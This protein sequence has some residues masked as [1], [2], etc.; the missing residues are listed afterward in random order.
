MPLKKKGGQPASEDIAEDSEMSVSSP[1]SEASTDTTASIALSAELLQQILASTQA[2]MLAGQR[3]LQQE[4]LA[5]QQQMASERAQERLRHQQTLVDSQAENQ[6]ALVD[7]QRLLL[8]DS[9]ATMARNY[10]E[11]MADN[12]AAM[13]ILIASL[14]AK[15]VVEPKKVRVDVPKWKE[16]EA[17]HEYFQ[18]YETAQ[19][20]NGV[21]RREWGVLLQVY[22][23]G[24]AQA[25]Y[26]QVNPDHYRDYDNLKGVMLRALRDTPEQADRNWWSLSRKAGET[27]NAF[28]IRMRTV[29]NRRFDGYESRE[30][31]FEKVLLS[32]FLYLLPAEQYNLVTMRDPQTTELAASILDD[33]ES[34]AEFANKH[35]VGGVKYGQSSNSYYKKDGGY[36]GSQG[37]NKGGGSY[38]SNVANPSGTHSVEP[39][40]QEPVVNG[41]V[42]VSSSAPTNAANTNVSSNNKPVRKNPIICYSCHEPGHIKPNCPNRIRRLSPCEEDSE[43]DDSAEP[44]WVDG[45]IGQ[46]QITGMRYDSGCDRTVVDKQLV[47]AEAYIGQKVTLKGWR[48]K[49]TSN[50]ELARINIKVGKVLHKKKKVAVAEDMEY[51]A[52]LGAD[53]SR[54]IRCEIMKRVM[55]EWETEGEVGQ[56]KEAEKSEAVRV[57][58]AQER[59]EDEAERAD[60]Q[61]SE[62]SDCTPIP[63]SEIFDF[64]DE[65]F[66]D[67]V[68]TPLAELGTWLVE[69]A[70]EPLVAPVM[71]TCIDKQSLQKEQ[72]EDATLT[73]LHVLAGEKEKGYRYEDGILLQGEE[74]CLGDVTSRIVVPLGRRQKLLEL[75]HSG[76]V[77]GHFGVKKTYAK[78]SGHFIWPKMWVQV[79]ELVRT[80]P[81]CQRASRNTNAK[82]PLQP[83]P[84]I[85]EP[86]KLVAFDI[87]GPIPRS[88]SGYKYI[89]TMM[90]LYTK[91]PEAIP[92]KRVDN[93]AVLEGMMEVFTRHGIPERILTDQGTVFMSRLTKAV[94]STLGID[95]IR[96][97]PYH[98]QSN[99]ALER[100]H[101][102]LKGMLKRSEA[103]LKYWDRHLKYLLFAYRDTPHCITGFSPFSLLFGREVKGPLTL[104][105]SSWLEGESEGV[106][107]SVWVTALKQQMALMSEVVTEKEKVAKAKM[108]QVF[109]KSAKEKSFNV[110]DLVLIRKPGLKGKLGDSWDGPYQILEKISPLNYKIQ[111]PGRRS[112]VLHVNLL[113]KWSTP[114]ARV[115][116]VAV[117]HEEEGESESPQ[118]LRLTRDG[119]VPTVEQQQLLDATLAKY[120]EVLKEMPGRTKEITLSIDTA[121]SPPLR[122]HPYRIPPKWREEVKEQID[123]LLGLG[124]IEVSA[125]P[126]SSAVVTVRKKT[127]GVRICIDYRAINSVTTP[128]PYQMPFIEDILDTL[129]SAKYMSKID[130]NKGF[131]QIPVQQVDKAKTAFCTPWGKYQFTMMPF[132]LRNGPAVF[133]R[134]M[135]KLLH[136]DLEY[137]RVYID[138][139]VVFS[140]SW[141]QHC[142]HLGKVLERLRAAGLTANISKCQWGQVKFDFLGH[143][144]GEGMV[145]PSEC[146]IL[147]LRDYQQPMTKKGIRQFLGLAGYYRKFIQDY[148]DHSFNLTNATR[149]SASDRV[150]WCDVML[151]EFCY[152][153]SVLCS[154]PALTL[155]EDNF[156]LQTDASSLGVG[157]ILSVVREEVEFPVAYFSR[158]LKPREQK[159]SATELEGL[160]VMNAVQHFDTYL[161]THPFVV[162]TD[163]RALVFLNSTRHA[164]GRLARWALALQPYTFTLK[165][166]AGKLNSNA[167]AL[168]RCFEEENTEL[169]EGDCHRPSGGGGDVM[170]QQ[171][172]AEHRQSHS[173]RGRATAAEAEP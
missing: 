80:C 1:L 13:A 109:D 27:L 71:D 31:L 87:V 143:M 145:S 18:K 14:P 148:A 141:E 160:A 131:H 112:K 24:T 97:T 95:Q 77:S 83:L 98:P 126:W 73:P 108:K 121:E 3:A 132:G 156:V 114:V 29:A 56:A 54:A 43:E 142:L 147:A 128:D 62:E 8:A 60:V 17:P 166:R 38:Q 25:A 133:Q 146:K 91:Y 171:P 124:I 99:G 119:F 5:Y 152:L 168:S 46:Q 117:I 135:D 48:G 47:P 86:F 110:G 157:A 30:A 16:G 79:K 42:A 85:G 15:P 53:M 116:G 67:T 163:H 37:Y 44:N 70:E 115:H 57:T 20:H 22:L 34:R 51:P 74:D 161:V 94:C 118:G 139:I 84:C 65:L 9:Q 172:A 105:H 64:G 127:G 162:V 93:E 125:S 140:T 55:Q 63:L 81:G 58:R 173:S 165:Y 10:K 23:S 2:N 75:A 120:P 151:D 134:L 40:A 101:A 169:M 159:Y 68:A 100:W 150:D 102:C 149:K 113:K 33:S 130:L 106:E 111:T 122:S 66:E 49:Q 123:Q 61:A 104:V 82:A 11:S 164:N 52:L 137:S 92:L 59:C 136:Q 39:K 170:L 32:R 35:L 103:D 96:T 45:W 36:K 78:L 129:S 144:V 41:K 167:D 158:K 107:A 4:R 12:Q 6:Q 153:K 155:P 26:S 76:L 72:A 88:S 50:H 154:V 19:E 21:D 69:V 7:N 89:L 90:D 28:Q 138:D